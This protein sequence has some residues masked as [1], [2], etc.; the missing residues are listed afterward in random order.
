MKIVSIPTPYSQPL[1]A[2]PP[3]H[4][5]QSVQNA[6]ARLIFKACRRDHIQLLLR[7][8]HWLR[9]PERIYFVSAGSAGV[10][11]PPRLCT[12]LPGLRSSA[13]VTPQCT[14]TT[15]LF[16]YIIAGRSTH[17]AFYHWRPHLSSDCCISLSESVR[18]SLSLQVLR[19]RLKTELFAWSY[20]HE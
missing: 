16:D 11:L 8:L 17:C 18:S 12:W 19:S 1:S 15:A 2:S 4:R 5:L 3:H 7:R 6:A 20:N 10:S 13:R 14:S 9:M